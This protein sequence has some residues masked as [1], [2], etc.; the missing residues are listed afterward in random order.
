MLSNTHTGALVGV[1]AVILLAACSDVSMADE[2]TLPPVLQ[3]RIEEIGEPQAS[4][5]G[6]GEVTNAELEA[7]F[8]EAVSCMEDAGVEAEPEF[9][10]AGDY[11]MSR[12]AESEGDLGAQSDA[13]ETCLEQNYNLTASV[14]AALYGPTEKEYDH[15]KQLVVECAHELGIDGDTFDE[16]MENHSQIS[17]GAS[18]LPCLERQGDYLRRVT[19]ERADGRR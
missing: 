5:L 7:A 12:K 4:V 15:A 1:A 10:G 16:V 13:I 18:F 17:E 9:L 6:D 14:Y 11:R 8:F 2:R 19:A 3:D